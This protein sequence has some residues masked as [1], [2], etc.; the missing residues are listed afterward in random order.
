MLLKVKAIGDIL[1]L[2][3]F[4]LIEVLGG[5]TMEK[6]YVSTLNNIS[7]VG[8]NLL[9]DKYALT[10][11]ISK[12]NGILVRSQDM[13]DMNFSENLMAIARAG[14]GSQQYSFRKMC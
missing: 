2:L 3:V 7:S 8:L 6:F 9:S 5:I 12:A 14:A 13:H 10:E 11:D 4:K 1:Y